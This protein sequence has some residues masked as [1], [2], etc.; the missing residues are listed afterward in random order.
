MQGRA[1]K[2]DAMPSTIVQA[3]PSFFRH[4]A[5]FYS[6]SAGFIDGAAA[7]VRDAIENAEPVLVVVAAEKI[8][9]LQ[10]EL[11]GDDTSDVAFADMAEVGHNPARII[12]AWREFVAARAGVDRPVRGIG[13][14]IY[15][16]RSANEL[17]E[18]Q[19]HENLLNVAFTG[20]VGWWLLCP[21]DVAALSPDVVAEA[22][23]SHPFVCADGRHSPS[24]AV[25]DLAAM[26]EPP[27]AP[28]PDAPSNAD[29]L[30]FSFPQDLAAVRC[31]V[32]A[33]AVR[34]GL[35]REQIDAIV[36]AAD[37]IAA[38]GLHHGNGRAE[39]RVWHTGDVVTCE[40]ENAGR[41]E[42]PLA[43]R[44]QPA[45]FDGRGRGMWLANQ[46]CDLVQVRSRASGSV[47]RIHLRAASVNVD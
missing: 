10:A 4:E 29:T 36:L 47:V 2:G 45:V 43:G 5:L 24:S 19:H 32:R 14:P 41:F 40:V 6:G 12:P 38:N 9:A 25:R 21:Y 8:R 15:P 23:R 7:F 27:A 31:V 20:G 34:A 26:A 13:E 22:R 35:D 17:V 37:E 46:L 30:Y 42:A 16:A 3:E 11:S 39:L 28:L 33:H 1:T 44:E 18:C